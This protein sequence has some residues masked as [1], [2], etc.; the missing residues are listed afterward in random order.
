[1]V[2]RREKKLLSAD[3]RALEKDPLISEEINNFQFGP[4]ELAFNFAPLCGIQIFAR[5]QVAITRRKGSSANFNLSVWLT[6]IPH[7]N[8]Y[9][10]SLSSRGNAAQLF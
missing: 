9:L 6:N 5:T 2:P 8:V 4:Y 3:M 10:F 1:M 7:F